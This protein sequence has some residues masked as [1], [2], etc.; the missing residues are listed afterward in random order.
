MNHNW[1]K[2]PLLEGFSK[3]ATKILQK[4]IGAASTSPAQAMLATM[5]IGLVQVASGLVAGKLFRKKLI[6]SGKD[7]LGAF[8]YGVLFGT[9]TILTFVIFL[10]G[11][12]V[13]V[14][15][16]IITLA[17][18]PGLLIDWFYFD[19]KIAS[20]QWLGIVVAIIAGYAILDFPKTAEVARFPLWV[21]LSFIVMLLLAINQGITQ[22]LKNIN[23]VIL[24]FWGGLA[25]TVL[26][27]AG[28]VIFGP[29]D[30]LAVTRSFWLLSIL[31][32]F[33]FVLI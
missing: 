33:I 2:W 30:L 15:T 19:R 1:I 3:S 4:I 13:G 28:L 32:A 7:I 31:T 8:F 6:A 14:N 22:K 20:R 10:L 9:A 27:F 17:I 16:F 26:S 21:W 12:Q 25:M 24:N 18:V 5:V 11:G 29:I 23:P